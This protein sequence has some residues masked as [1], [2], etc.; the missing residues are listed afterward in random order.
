MAKI[1]LGKR[2]RKYVDRLPFLQRAMWRLE[3]LGLWLFWQ[4]CGS[5]SPDRASAFGSAVLR[6][7]GPR[8]RKHRHFVCNL[9]LA[10]PDKTESEIESLAREAW[11]NL[12][13]V[14]AEYPH[15]ETICAGQADRRLDIVVE[16]NIQAL[17]NSGTSAI[18]VAAHLANWEILGA[19]LGRLGL[20]LA[21]VYMP[22]SNP[23]VDG[24]LLRKR[25][26]LGCTL[27]NVQCGLREISRCLG[28]GASIGLLIDQRVDGG[29]LLPFFG[30]EK[31]T[32]LVPA[33]LALRYHCELVPVQ[34]VRLAGAHFRVTFH[35]PVRCESMVERADRPVEMTSQV[36][37]LFESWIRERPDEWLCSNRRW[38]KNATPL[39][40]DK[41][42]HLARTG[43]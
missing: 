1:L 20:P 13:A 3:A 37:S 29:E 18:Y 11:G 12:G 17:R 16:G 2:V 24:M 9:A 23:I 5:L 43:R 28:R 30:I 25:A 38:P 33:R 41:A 7:F 34:V 35:E 26:A 32:T 8:L 31:A 14:A 15:L 6:L 39:L 42:G 21:V 27:L 40:Q 10:F 22:A 19:T 36:N 4:L